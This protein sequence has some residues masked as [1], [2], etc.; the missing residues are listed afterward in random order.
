M[1]CVGGSSDVHDSEADDVRWFKVPE[2][3]QVLRYPNERKIVTK[4]EQM[5]R[6]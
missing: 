5:M 1:R 2:A 4:A 3:I 6:G